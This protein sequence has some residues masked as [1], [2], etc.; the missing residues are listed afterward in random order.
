MQAFAET[1]R[2]LTA[3]RA[4]GLVGPGGSLEAATVMLMNAVF[5]D[6]MTRDVG[7]MSPPHSVPE[8]VEMFV[9]LIL[10]ALGATEEA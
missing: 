6:A 2:Y 1:T 5:M 4:K 10:R 7:P 9:E 3:A 8:V